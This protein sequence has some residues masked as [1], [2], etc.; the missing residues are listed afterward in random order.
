MWFLCGAR[1]ARLLAERAGSAGE[2][3]ATISRA[4]VNDKPPNG[5]AS[6]DWKDERP[7]YA[8]RAATCSPTWCAY[9]GNQV[10]DGWRF[11]AD[12]A[13]PARV[14]AA[15]PKRSARHFD[16]APSRAAA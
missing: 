7:Y 3:R 5:L 1:A 9:P 15:L 13:C 6:G 10:S 2:V 4:S 8:C 12:D 11:A 14:A 16:D